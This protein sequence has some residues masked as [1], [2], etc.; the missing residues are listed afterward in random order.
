MSF[1]QAAALA[2]GGVIEIVGLDA[3]RGGD[4]V[5]DEFEPGALLGSEDDIF[6]DVSFYPFD[7]PLIDRQRER[8]KKLLAFQCE[9][10]Q[11]DEIGE[12]AGLGATF[13]FLW[14]Y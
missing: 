12:A 7:E 2:K 9:A 14:R 1:S 10:D 3:D 5:A 8:L 11:R 13:H 6:G 4:M